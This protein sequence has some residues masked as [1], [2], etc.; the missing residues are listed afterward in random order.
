MKK[1]SLCIFIPIL[2]EENN[3]PLLVEKLVSLSVS[4]SKIVL[5]I[6]P[7][8]DRSLEVGKE[9][10][11]R[12]ANVT[13]FYRESRPKGRG[14]AGK[15]AWI[16]CLDL[17]PDFILEMDADHS[18]DPKHI[19]EFLAAQKKHNADVVIGS[20]YTTGGREVRGFTRKL[21]SWFAE[22]YLKVVLGVTF[23]TDPSSGYRLFTRESVEQFDPQSLTSSDHR[24]TTEILFRVRRKRIVEIPIEFH[25][26]KFGT[27]KLKWTV[28]VKSLVSP[29]IW[30]FR[31]RTD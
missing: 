21:I 28:L 7:S 30:R 12:F 2:N 18:H 3:L 1:V 31:Q 22:K 17:K 5:V 24:I 23:L 29:L 9:L 25:D 10:E 14:N 27:T 19:P 6:D 26:R 20:R 13:V 4:A 15:D 16:Y 11:R 8:K